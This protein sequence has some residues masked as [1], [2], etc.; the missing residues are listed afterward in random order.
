MK[1]YT[2]VCLHEIRHCKALQI[3]EPNIYE[4]ASKDKAKPRC[5]DV[6]ISDT[7]TDDT[8]VIPGK[9]NII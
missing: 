3:R 5:F 1:K 8:T 2:A 7:Y 4:S 9:T 6:E